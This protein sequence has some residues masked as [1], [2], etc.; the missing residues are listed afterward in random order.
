MTNFCLQMPVGCL[1][2]RYGKEIAL[3]V[4]FLTGRIE[5]DPKNIC[6]HPGDGGCWC[7]GRSIDEENFGNTGLLDRIKAR[8]INE[9]MEMATSGIDIGT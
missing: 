9:P 1:K 2:G 8:L 6:E 5:H 4:D 7:F 3:N